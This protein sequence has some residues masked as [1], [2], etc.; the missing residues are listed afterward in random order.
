MS[1]KNF[2]FSVKNSKFSVKNVMNYFFFLYIFFLP[3]NGE[4]DGKKMW[5]S[6]SDGAGILPYK[7]DLGV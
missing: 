5:T 4:F 6:N 3:K 7:S 1:F 2:K